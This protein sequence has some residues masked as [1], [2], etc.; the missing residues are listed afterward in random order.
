M[1]LEDILCIIGMDKLK[2][3]CPLIG[4]F[5]LDALGTKRGWHENNE[6]VL[7]QLGDV[8]AGTFINK[9]IKK[10]L[11]RNENLLASTEIREE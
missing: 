7:R 10:R 8:Y 6:Y 4:F 3:T 2:N 9:A 11:E 1:I 5:G